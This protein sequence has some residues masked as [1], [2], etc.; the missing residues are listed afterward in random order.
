M[1]SCSPFRRPAA[2]ARKW[3]WD[4][5]WWRKDSCHWPS[6]LWYIRSRPG[7]HLCLQVWSIVNENVY[8]KDESSVLIFLPSFHPFSAVPNKVVRSVAQQHPVVLRSECWHN[9][10]A[11]CVGGVSALNPSFWIFWIWSYCCPG[12]CQCHCICFTHWSVCLVCLW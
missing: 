10:A 4:R 11:L 3:V 7:E 2:G 1:E 5:V 12:E 6:Q 8:V 9:T